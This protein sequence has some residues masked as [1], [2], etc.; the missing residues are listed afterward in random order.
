VRAEPKTIGIAVVTPNHYM[1]RPMPCRLNDKLTLLFEL[2]QARDI[3]IHLRVSIIAMLSAMRPLYCC[4][5]PSPMF[6]LQ[7]G[8]RI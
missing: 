5:L 2:R 7:L 6:L 3:R 8:A 4:S 1:T